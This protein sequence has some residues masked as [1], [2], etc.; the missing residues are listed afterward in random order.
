MGWHLRFS[1]GNNVRVLALK[2]SRGQLE[3]VLHLHPGWKLTVSEK[4]DHIEADFTRKASP[5]EE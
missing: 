3:N 1:K 2:E 5:Y 4:N